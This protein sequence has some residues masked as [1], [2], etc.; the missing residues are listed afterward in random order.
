MIDA[1]TVADVRGTHRPVMRDAHCMC[2]GYM[3][4]YCEG[5]WPCD[6]ERWLR[7]AGVR[8]HGIDDYHSGRV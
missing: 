5:T 7:D 6:A 8:P 3:C 2:G 1:A 4:R